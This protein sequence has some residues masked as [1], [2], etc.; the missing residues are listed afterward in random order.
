LYNMAMAVVGA[1][2]T[3]EGTPR[4]CPPIGA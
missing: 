3:V 4:Q 1:M 2:G